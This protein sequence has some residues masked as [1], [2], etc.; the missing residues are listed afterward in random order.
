[1]SNLKFFSTIWKMYR[2]RLMIYFVILVKWHKLKWK[3]WW[4]SDYQLFR[5]FVFLN[6]WKKI[7]VTKNYMFMSRLSSLFI[8]RNNVHIICI[9]EMVIKTWNVLGSVTLFASVSIIPGKG[10]L[11]CICLLWGIWQLRWICQ[12]LC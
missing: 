12:Y 7:V 9:P 1:M 6:R 3:R 10:Q 4:L 5:L 11:L 2:V 8:E